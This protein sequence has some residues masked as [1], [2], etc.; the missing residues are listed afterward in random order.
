MLIFNKVRSGS[1]SAAGVK[2]DY[3]AYKTEVEEHF[4]ATSKKF[5]TMTEQYQ[6]LYQHLSVGATTLCRAD[7]VAA[8]LVDSSNPDKPAQIEDSSATQEAS[9]EAAD[10]NKDSDKANSEEVITEEAGASEATKEAADSESVEPDAGNN[11]GESGDD[12]T[13]PSAK[14]ID[15]RT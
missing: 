13:E 10:T 8:A 12:K 3:D 9:N 15:R 5:Q 1:T 14:V 2:Q 4:E 7:S 11:E 6:D